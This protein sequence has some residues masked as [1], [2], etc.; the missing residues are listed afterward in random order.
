MINKDILKTFKN[1]IL[2]STIGIVAVSLGLYYIIDDE[3]PFTKIETFD[4]GISPTEQNEEDNSLNEY[5]QTV[6]TINNEN[7]FI[8]NQLKA[9]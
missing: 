6:G 8:K 2:I 4:D 7:N 9:G 1:N 3:Y 5:N